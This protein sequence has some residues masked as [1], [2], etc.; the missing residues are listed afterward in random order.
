[1]RF[2]LPPTG[3]LVTIRAGGTELVVAPECGARLVA[4]RVDG[5][6]VLRPASAEALEKAVPYG[7]AVLSPHTLFRSD[8]WRWISL[9]RSVAR[10]RAERSRRADRHAR[11]GLDQAVADNI[12]KRS[13]HLARA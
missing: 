13:I 1:M 10:A 9:R 11:R 3:K 6:D 12:R 7:F 4:F 8:L 5:R 2:N